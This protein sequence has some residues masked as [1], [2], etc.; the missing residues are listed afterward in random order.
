MLSP[1]TS[2]RSDVPILFSLSFHPIA[3][4]FLSL[5]P[6]DRLSAFFVAPIPKPFAF[7]QFLRPAICYRPRPLNP[8]SAALFEEFA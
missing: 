7:S 1:G 2:T 4:Y 5:S 8:L 6:Y 3:F